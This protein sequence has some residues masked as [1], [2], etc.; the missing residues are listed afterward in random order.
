MAVFSKPRVGPSILNRSDRLY[1]SFGEIMENN[2]DAVR[3]RM[4]QV[5]L[6]V[7]SWSNV[8]IAAEAFERGVKVSSGQN[9]TRVI[10]EDGNIR[11]SWRWGTSSLNSRLAIR[12]VNQKE[13]TS[14]LLRGAGVSAPENAV[15]SATDVERAWQWARSIKPLVLKPYNA[16]QGADVHVGIDTEDEFKQAFVQIAKD[17]RPVLIEQHHAGVERRCFVV[18]NRLVATLYRR[19]A[20]VVGDGVS[21]IRRLV[22]LKNADRGLIHRALAIGDEESYM[23]NRQ[24]RSI[25]SVPALGERIYLR[26]IPN[27]HAGSDA[28]DATDEVSVAEREFVESAA[29]AV[30]GLRYAGMDVLFSRA[31]DQQES[32]IIE[33]N[34][35]PMTSMHHFPWTGQPRNVSR[36]ILD[37]MFP[38]VD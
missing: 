21:S 33:I 17:D 19:P 35:N 37:A 4:R 12:C 13:V 14:R 16:L 23:L 38:S 15:F 18:D 25:M 27:I 24:G 28:I 1:N 30:P 10:L 34:H 36:A 22:D 9:G 26:S 32:S 29:R 3:T 7:G 31:G 6:K 11:H 8:L 5:G 20:N 2:Y